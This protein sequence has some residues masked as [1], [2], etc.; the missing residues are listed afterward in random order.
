M[1]KSVKYGLILVVA[2]T[3]VLS[4]AKEIVHAQKYVT[5]VGSVVSIHKKS[6]AVKDNKGITMN[7]LMGRKTTFDPGRL[8][9]VG[10]RVEV[11]YYLKRGQ[12]V[13]YQ[14]KIKAAQ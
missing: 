9:N 12:N 10:E 13:A 5:F 6:L 8:P 4:I 7:F 11:D 3:M 2:F 1:R 14:V